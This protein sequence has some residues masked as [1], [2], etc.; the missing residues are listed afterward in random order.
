MAHPDA[1]VEL[2]DGSR[3][4]RARAAE[5]DERER[6]WARWRDFSKS[7]GDPDSYA[8]KR[9]SRTDVVVLEPQPDGHTDSLRGF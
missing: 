7:A 5:L 2:K 9:S 1:R 8:A 4:V 3:M 6:L